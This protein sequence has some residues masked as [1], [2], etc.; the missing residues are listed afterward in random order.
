MFVCQI[1]WSC[2]YVPP[3]GQSQRLAYEGIKE[4]NGSGRKRR[5]MPVRDGEG[6]LLTK[7]VDIRNR[8]REHFETVLNRPVPPEE[9]IPPVQEDLNIDTGEIR[10][11]EVVTTLKQLKN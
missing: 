5:E 10:L 6:N 3:S 11:E 2:K 4:L 8:W 7:N 1:E 9:D